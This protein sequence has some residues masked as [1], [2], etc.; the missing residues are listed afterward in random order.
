MSYIPSRSD[1]V[2]IDFD[3]ALGHEQAKR[4]PAVVISPIIYNRH[5]LC[6]VCPITSQKKGYDYEVDIPNGK[7]KGVILCDQLKSFDWRTRRIKYICPL[8]SEIFEE[9]QNKSLTLIE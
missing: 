9:V 1:I 4:R 7:V 8:A 6:I 2:W 5:G 3:P